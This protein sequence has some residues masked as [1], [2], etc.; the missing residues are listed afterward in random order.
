MSVLTVIQARTG[1]TR[2]PGKVMYPLN[3]KPVLTHVIERVRAVD[4]VDRTVVA[5][6]TEPP[7][8]VVEAC[9]SRAGAG[10][11]RGSEADV[12]GR[13]ERVVEE[14]DPDTLVRVTADCPLLSPTVLDSVVERLQQSS[15]DYSSNTL[16]RTFPRGLDVEAFTAESFA[17]VAE[18]AT[19]P[20]HREHVTPYYHEREDHFERV[21]VTAEGVFAEEWLQNHTDLRLTLD[22][23]A[24]YEL[25]RRVYAE[26]PHGGLLDVRDAIRHVD[27]NGLGELNEH[28]EQKET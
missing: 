21:S 27:E 23:P 2:L 28:V 26:V 6:S 5:T 22:E 13:F 19:E 15:A 25:L 8:E 16:E 18:E 14:H 24:D 1:S 17:T 7:D 11:V 20:H 9:A 10:V 3:G 12:L 4:A